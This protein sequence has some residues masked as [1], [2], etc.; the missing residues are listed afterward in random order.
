MS[1]GHI[2]YCETCAAA[3]R[4][5]DEARVAL[6]CVVDGIVSGWRIE[7]RVRI[8]EHIAKGLGGRYESHVGSFGGEFIGLNA[9]PVQSAIRGTEGK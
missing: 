8:Y 2:I 5:R 9:R 6:W 1:E 7:D 4:E 3:I